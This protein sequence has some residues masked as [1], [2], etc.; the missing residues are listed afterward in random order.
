M[1]VLKQ[2]KT[3]SI[4]EHPRTHKGF[5]CHLHNHLSLALRKN[6]QGRLHNKKT[7]IF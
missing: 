6:A 4:N 5:D 3:K 7:R 2:T 1:L